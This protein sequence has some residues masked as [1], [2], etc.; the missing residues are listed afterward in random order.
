VIRP[1]L[2]TV[3]FFLALLITTACRDDP[4]TVQSVAG[5]YTLIEA[6]ES[7]LPTVVIDTIGRTEEITGGELTFFEFAEYVMTFDFRITVQTVSGPVVTDSTGLQTGPFTIVGDIIEMASTR[8]GQTLY[9]TVDGS[10]ITVGIP[11][12]GPNLLLTYKR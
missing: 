8:R 5:V 10:E 6:N 4:L 3:A 9:G 2:T 11:R 7:R 12:E 1:I